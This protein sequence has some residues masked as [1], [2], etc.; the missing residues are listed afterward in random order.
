M[1][2][3]GLH[4]WVQKVQHLQW[5]THATAYP[6]MHACLPVCAYVQARKHIMLAASQQTVAQ[7]VRL[8][9]HVYVFSIH[10]RL[11]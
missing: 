2:A 6:C 5:C 11:P 1:H 8:M 4:A 9:I 10:S 7:V 3:R